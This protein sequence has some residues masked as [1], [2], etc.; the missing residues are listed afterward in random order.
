V[1]SPLRERSGPLR[2]VH[3]SRLSR[4]KGSMA[5]LE[6][7]RALAERGVEFEAEVIGAGGGGF[8]QEMR[9]YVERH[10]LGMVRLLGRLDQDALIDRLERADVL[11]HLSVSDSYPLIV[12][13]ALG[14][15]VYPICMELPG[16]SEIMGRFAG[17]RVSFENPVEETVEAIA[18]AQVDEL[19]A[20]AARAAGRV[21]EEFAWECCREVVEGALASVTSGAR[22]RRVTS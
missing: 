14:C 3:A 10:E 21:K 9:D 6:V 16:A 2:L 11:V 7:C 12:I 4:D 15:G 5:F 1:R 19:R 22:T 18:Q 20:E 8:E 13:E 17:K